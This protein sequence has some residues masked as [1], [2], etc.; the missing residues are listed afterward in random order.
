MHKLKNR[1]PLAKITIGVVEETRAV[2]LETMRD[3]IAEELN[4]KLVEIT[5]DPSS[6][7]RIFVKP[8]FKVLGKKMGDKMKDLQAALAQ[9][10]AAECQRALQKQNIT[11]LGV[12]LTPEMVTVELQGT[13]HQLVATDAELVDALDP[14]LSEE[15]KLEGLAREV[16]SLVQKARKSALFEVEDRILLMVKT[17]DALFNA[18]LEKNK[19]YLEEET[20]AQVVSSLSAADYEQ[21]IEVDG[22]KLSLHLKR[23]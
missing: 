11:A 14:T 5:R 10:S 20:L 15:L 3:F 6:L 19:S 9:L 1:Q 17:S 2:Q 7:A 12:D 13:G 21:D 8:N 18:A 23:K 22:R 4:V 16:V